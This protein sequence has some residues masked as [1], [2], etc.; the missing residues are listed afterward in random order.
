MQHTLEMRTAC[1]IMVGKPEEKKQ[2]E[3]LLVDWRI[4]LDWILGK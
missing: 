4:I 1:K 3:D 2:S